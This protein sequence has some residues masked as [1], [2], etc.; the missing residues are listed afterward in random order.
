MAVTVLSSAPASCGYLL[1]LWLCDCVCGTVAFMRGF[2]E[3]R[4]EA[5]VVCLLLRP[6]LP[7]LCDEGGRGVVGSEKYQTKATKAKAAHI[8][9][10]QK[11][12]DKGTGTSKNVGR[13]HF[14]F[15]V[16]LVPPFLLPSF[17]LNQWLREHLPPCVVFLLPLV[18]FGLPVKHRPCLLLSW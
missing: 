17:L 14:E 6:L 13:S 7:F 16:F 1:R 10:T 11:R 4:G 9:A 2:G 5:R 15:G 12:G 3:G 18:P 8:S